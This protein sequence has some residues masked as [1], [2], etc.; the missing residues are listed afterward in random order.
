[1]LVVLFLM[2]M[3]PYWLPTSGWLRDP[4]IQ[5]LIVVLLT[6]GLVGWWVIRP[7]GGEKM[8]KTMKRWM[9]TKP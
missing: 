8:E 1:V 3:F 7:E 9:L 4:A 6:M 5:A 2:N